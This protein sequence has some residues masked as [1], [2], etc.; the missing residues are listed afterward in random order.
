MRKGCGGKKGKGVE[1]GASNINRK[2]GCNN[3]LE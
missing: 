1:D 3:T 2:E